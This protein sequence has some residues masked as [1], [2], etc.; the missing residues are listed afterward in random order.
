MPEANLPRKPIPPRYLTGTAFRSFSC[1]AVEMAA[2]G[3]IVIGPHAGTSAAIM[4]L[5]HQQCSWT[6]GQR[7]VFGPLTVN[8]T[9]PSSGAVPAETTKSPEIG[10]AHV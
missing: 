3:T 4:A 9:T 8:R 10:R 1:G 7:A 2:K 5:N 6:P